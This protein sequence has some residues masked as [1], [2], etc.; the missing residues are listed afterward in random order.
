MLI[1][2]NTDDLDLYADST[3]VGEDVE[4][5]TLFQP[6]GKPLV[7]IDANLTEEAWRENHLR[8]T[9]THEM[10]HVKFQ[11]FLWAGRALQAR[12]FGK[13][14][15]SSPARCKRESIIG[16]NPSDWME[17]QAG[18]ASGATLM[19]IT[20]HKKIALEFSGKQTENK[21]NARGEVPTL[22]VI[23]LTDRC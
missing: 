2:E 13:P 6:G 15:N 3:D 17:W 8:T 1:E 22:G 18:F 12:L 20:P 21:T 23:F 19:P 10:G 7:H 14:S 9:L 11:C 5:V 4:D 16:A